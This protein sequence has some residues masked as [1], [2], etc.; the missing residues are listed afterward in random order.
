MCHASLAVIAVHT[1]FTPTMKP[2][3]VVRLAITQ[4]R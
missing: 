3:F 2:I 4:Y 1:L